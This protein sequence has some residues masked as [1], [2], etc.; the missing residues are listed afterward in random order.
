MTWQLHSGRA[1]DILPGD[2]AGAVDMVFTSP[3]YDGLRDFG[4]ATA[5]HWDFDAVVD[6][7]IACLAPGGVI[8]W[9]EGDA[10]VDGSES[11]TSFRNALRLKDKGLRLHQTLVYERWSINGMSPNRYYRTHEYVF[12]LSLGA[13]KTVNLIMDKPNAYAG[14]TRTDGKGMGRNK[15]GSTG[16]TRKYWMNGEFSRRGSVWKYKVGGR[17]NH[18]VAE[19][20]LPHEHPSANSYPLTAD[21]I[22]TWS[23][24]GDLVLDPMAGSGT[25][26][27]AAVNLGRRAA[28]IEVNPAYCDLIRRRMAQAVL[29]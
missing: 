22:R 28:M 21:H 29:C 19:G 11:G 24:P 15:D 1:Q 8:C 13:P 25:T 6:S 17:H 20:S 9:L 3:P 5:A 4:G 23:N 26:G 27:R 18:P 7:V 2:L 16:M 14:T 12:V 10:I